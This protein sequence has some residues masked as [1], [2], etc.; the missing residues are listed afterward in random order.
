MKNLAGYMIKQILSTGLVLKDRVARPIPCIFIG[1]MVL[2]T[3][4]SCGILNYSN[5]VDYRD[6]KRFVD[7]EE[8]AFCLRSPCLVPKFFC[9]FSI[10]MRC[11]LFL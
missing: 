1:L 11:C 7:S 5:T 3:L 6:N 2:N 10:V 8:V 9:N 4:F